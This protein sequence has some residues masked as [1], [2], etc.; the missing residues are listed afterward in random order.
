MVEATMP[1]SWP[2]LVNTAPGE[3]EKL[4]VAPQDVASCS[5]MVPV[6]EGIVNVEAL[7]QQLPGIMQGEMR[8]PW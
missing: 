6:R 1:K 5:I 4:E 8:C 2:W 3:G 7:V